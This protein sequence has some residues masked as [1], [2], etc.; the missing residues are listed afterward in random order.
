MR[1]P[2]AII[3]I[4]IVLIRNQLPT[5]NHSFS[6]LHHLEKKPTS[7]ADTSCFPLPSLVSVYN[8]RSYWHISKRLFVPA[9]PGHTQSQTHHYFIMILVSCMQATKWHPR[10]TSN[11]YAMLRSATSQRRCI[12]TSPKDQLIT[13]GTWY[14]PDPSRV[15]SKIVVF[16]FSIRW[17]IYLCITATFRHHQTA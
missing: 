12:V 9:F 7:V 16:Q 1:S 6:S 10:V 14:T 13:A 2:F 15:V 4:R 8:A 11:M 5:Y 3:Q 17:L